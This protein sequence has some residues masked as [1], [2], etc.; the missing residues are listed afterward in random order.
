VRA[1]KEFTSLLEPARVGVNITEHAPHRSV[2]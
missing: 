2:A 1:I